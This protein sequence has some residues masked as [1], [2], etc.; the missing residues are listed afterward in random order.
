MLIRCRLVALVA[1]MLI[2]ALATTS[3][4]IAADITFNLN[5]EGASLGQI[6]RLGDTSFRCHVRGQQDERGRNRQATW[7][8]FRMDHVADKDLTIILTDFVGEYHNQPGANPMGPDILPVLSADNQ[9]WR[10][11][12]HFKWDPEKKEVTLNVHA[13][14]D[15]IWV[16]HVPPYT[17]SDLNRLLD[18][19]KSRPSAAVEVIGKTVQ[20]R[21]LSL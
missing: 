2:E 11:F 12:P 9:H 18:E 7:Y 3:Q 5:F 21:D 17:P 8:Y 10:H 1:I 14:G 13:T 4:A 20:G 15:S 19:I 16:A 6:E